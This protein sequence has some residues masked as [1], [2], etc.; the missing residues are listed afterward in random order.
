MSQLFFLLAILHMKTRNVPPA[1]WS[2]QKI[3]GRWPIASIPPA[4][5]CS[6]PTDHFTAVG[7]GR[8]TIAAKL[9]LRHTT[10]TQTSESSSPQAHGWISRRDSLA[11]SFS[12]L[13]GPS[14]RLGDHS[15]LR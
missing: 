8:V 4:K 15:R 9:K 2:R 11:C 1:K 13:D 6:D 3:S 14:S 7:V 5:Q 12:R 10:E